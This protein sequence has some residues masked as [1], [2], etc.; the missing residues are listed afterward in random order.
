MT[1]AALIALVSCLLGIVIV[2]VR[3]VVVRSSARV[4][5]SGVSVSRRWLIE[6]QSND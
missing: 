2:I 1:I 5:L 6:H 3:R 4:L